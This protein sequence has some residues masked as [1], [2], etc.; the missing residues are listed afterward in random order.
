VVRQAIE[1][2]WISVSSGRTFVE[3]LVPAA[4]LPDTE[5]HANRVALERA[6]LIKALCGSKAFLHPARLYLHEA[7]AVTGPPIANSALDRSYAYVQNS[8][9]LPQSVQSTA[10]KLADSF[11]RGLRN[12]IK[13][14]TAQVLSV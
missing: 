14:Q 5:K 3:V 11:V 12:R 6:R 4:P 2:T 10:R 13:T 9:W 1:T 8:N 7:R